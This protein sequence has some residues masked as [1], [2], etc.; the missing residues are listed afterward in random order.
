MLELIVYLPL[1]KQLKI[2]TQHEIYE[3]QVFLKFKIFSA[4]TSS[5]EMTKVPQ[6]LSIISIIQPIRIE[7]PW[8]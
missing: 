8:K 2:L 6:G 4:K 1:T 5:K 7:Y 3:K